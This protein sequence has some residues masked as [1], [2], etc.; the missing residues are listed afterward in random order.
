MGRIAI[1]CVDHV[2]G[3][4]TGG[5]IIARMVVRAEK[6]QC[7][8][9][10]TCFLQ[11]EEDRI[12]ALCSAEAARAESLVRLSWIF[13]FIGQTDFEPPLAA[14]FKHTQEVSRLRD[15]PAWNRIEQGQKT[16]GAAFFFSACLQQ[17]L[18]CT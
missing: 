4:T 12:G 6:I 17:S 1:V 9:E 5:A 8:I 7:W 18:R 11:S 2:T 3:G 15:L 16:F 14:A 10:Q 13:F